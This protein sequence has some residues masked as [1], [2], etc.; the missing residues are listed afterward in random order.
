M[1]SRPK[2]SKQTR[3][4][5]ALD[6]FPRLLGER[7]C[8]NFVNTLEKMVKDGPAE[9]LPG[10]AELARWGQHAR[11][12]SEAEVE[13][14]LHWATGSSTEADD[15]FDRAI[16]LRSGLTRIFTAIAHGQSPAEGDL[17]ILESEYIRAAPALRLRPA[18]EHFVW[19][20]SDQ[21]QPVSRLL[22]E[23]SDSAVHVL[24]TDDLSRIKE[25][26][27]ANDCGSLFYDTSR[28]GTRRWCSMEGCGSRVK[29]RRQYARQTGHA[30]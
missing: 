13:H 2:I 21:T 17:A 8:L 30:T 29:M 10:F 24:T 28:N 7:L 12:L 16:R 26:P 18:G 19:Q 23:I 25:C 5:G 15:L 1:A 3:G 4:Q 6:H 27:G 14:S 20:W 22:W 11:E 9:F